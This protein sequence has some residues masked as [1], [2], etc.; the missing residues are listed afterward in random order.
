MNCIQP[1]AP[2][3]LGPMLRP[4][5]DSTLLIAASTSHGIPYAEPARFQRSSSCAASSCSDCA[6]GASRSSGSPIDPASFG[7]NALGRAVVLLGTIVNV[8]ARALA[9]TP[10]TA[11]HA[12]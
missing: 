2:A 3:E 1:I 12:T 11:R 8:S 6:G 7:S 5:F 4:K 9:A 10:A